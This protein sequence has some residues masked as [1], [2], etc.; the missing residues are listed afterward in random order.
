MSGIAEVLL[1]LGHRVSGSD[2]ATSLI[3][4]HLCNK[5][6]TISI[7]HSRQHISDDIDVVVTSTAVGKDNIE[8]IAAKEKMIPVI[9]RAEMLAELMRLKYGVAVAGTHGKTTTTSMIATILSEAGLDPTIVIGGRLNILG[10]NAKLGQGDLLV[11]EADESDGSFLKLSPTIAV[12]TTIDEEHLDHYGN[13]EAIQTAFLEFINKVPFYGAAILCIDQENIQA[14]IPRIEKKVLTYGFNSQAD[15]CAVDPSFSGSKSE[16]T[17]LWKGQEMGRIKLSSPGIHNILNTLG[18]IGAAFELDVDFETVRKALEEFTGADRRFQIKGEI[19]NIMIVDD[20]AH[21]PTEIRA[22]L[23]AAKRGW[24]RKVIA[25]FQPHRYT[26]TQALL[27]EFS[28]S[29]YQAD[30]LIV[31]KIYS[32][33][34]TPIEGVEAKQIANGVQEHGHRH[35]CFIPDFEEIVDHLQKIVRPGDTVL[36]LGAGNIYQIG[37]KLIEKLH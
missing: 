27:D 24:N 3:V 11:A 16:F 1:N 35:V 8:V 32:A 34:E 20:Y 30:E 9:P 21:H 14:L 10:S 18:A 36:T 13:L 29:F 7:G 5:G 23:A 6:A 31:T 2:T 33:G 15:F 28:K 22:T 26:R 37:E 25:V 17:L 4:E 12:V 19:N